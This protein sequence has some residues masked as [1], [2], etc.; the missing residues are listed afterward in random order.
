MLLKQKHI[1]RFYAHGTLENRVTAFLTNPN[2]FKQCTIPLLTT[3]SAITN[4]YMKN[5]KASQITRTVIIADG[6]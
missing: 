1:A 6:R 4:T 2:A 3:D 5:S